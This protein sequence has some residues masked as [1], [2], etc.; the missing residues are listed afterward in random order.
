MKHTNDFLVGLV[1]IGGTVA[2]LAFSVWLSQSGLGAKR[3][4]VIARFSD[5]GNAKVGNA[6]VIRGVQAGRI[7]SIEL[8]KSGWV[9]VRMALDRDVELPRDPIV[10]LSETSMFGEW[11]AT[12]MD[13]SAAPDDRDV[14]QQLAQS[15]TA[16]RG[17]LPGARLPDIA[18]LTAV[19]GRI[20]SDVSRVAE[21]FQVAFDDRA[22]AE[23]R[24]SI[25]N[26][27]DLSTQL[28][29]TVRTQSANLERISADVHHTVQA[30]DSTAGALQHTAVRVD[31][32]TA[33]GE[34]RQIVAN[35]GGASEDVRATSRDLR[36]ASRSLVA[37]QAQLASVLAHSDSVMRKIDRG[38]GSLG[39]MVNDPSLYQN[40]DALVTQMRALV[41]EIRA[42]PRRYL[43]VRIF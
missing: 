6:V 20:A 43:T 24:Q 36:E 41:A 5:V 40:S 34:L 37:S 29:R 42:H 31:S 9:L 17:A 39:L 19:A 11:Q 12:I 35:V 10:I 25:R 23:L 18:Q 13:R 26:F 16:G 7:Q 2:I 4:E 3:H 30:I 33:R 8:A 22:A 28:E 32:A 14:L 38:Q 27:S 15:G 21:R 1:V